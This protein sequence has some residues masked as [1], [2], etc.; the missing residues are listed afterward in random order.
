MSS[1]VII[2]SESGEDHDELT[3]HGMA[4]AEPNIGD[5]GGMIL[6]TT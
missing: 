4:R 5:D 2:L 6:K 1:A 3:E